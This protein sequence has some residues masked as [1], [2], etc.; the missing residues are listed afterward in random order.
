MKLSRRTALLLTLTL[1]AGCGSSGGVT[2]PTGVRFTL[3]WPDTTRALPLVAKSVR[4]QIKQGTKLLVERLYLA[5]PDSE[6]QLTDLPFATALTLVASAYTTTDGTGTVVASAS[7][8][9]S[10]LKG[11]LEPVTLTLASVI[12]RI[13]TQL[14]KGETGLTLSAIARDSAGSAVLTDP[15][16]WQWQLSDPTLGTLTPTGST[17][18]F[19]ERGF[20]I[21]QLTA[22]EKE[23]GKTGT[24][25]RPVCV[26]EP[27]KTAPTQGRYTLGGPLSSI[28][29]LGD[30][31]F[32]FV[33]G[34][35]LACIDSN[36]TL[37]WQRS[38]PSS[39]AQLTALP[40]G[41]LAVVTSAGLRIHSSET[42][43]FYWESTGSGAP[44]NATATAIFQQKTVAVTNE[45]YLE[46][47]AMTSGDLLWS[48]SLATQTLVWAD[49][50]RL[51]N[52]DRAAGLYAVFQSTLG[53]LTWSTSVPAQSQ[54]VGLR[55][56]GTPPLMLSYSPG[57]L[58]AILL[59]NGAK[60]WSVAASGEQVV[61]TPDQGKVLAFGETYCAS[62][63]AATGTP[64]WSKTGLRQVCGTLPSGDLLVLP[65]VD[66][67][68]CQPIQ[69]L[70]ASDG[71]VLWSNYL[72]YT[73]LPNERF[74]AVRVGS[75]VAVTLSKA[76]TY[77]TAPLY[78]L[79][80]TTG[81]YLWGTTVF[82][83]G[84]PGLAAPVGS[85]GALALQSATG[86]SELLVLH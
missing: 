21:A 18:S 26:G 32:A 3:D 23:S 63:D 47:R 11:K 75:Q 16:Q 2:T 19:V 72:P 82:G 4:V 41:F 10:T 68:T 45:P 38:L 8:P 66:D 76:A 20:G 83:G 24:L 57:E 58:R 30:G 60:L 7:I 73:P 81:Q 39:G 86:S 74:L 53:S 48:K 36:G 78:L 28:L 34:T 35:V 1:T 85:A 77:T 42:G 70:R 69:A 25:T 43:S 64:L 9:F 6:E 52:L 59:A 61:L 84:S 31:R 71:T 12:T 55:T 44:G 22:T 62:Y 14:T 40:G 80:T 65:T 79:D 56:S 49:S 33:H 67:P 50:T 27:S 37:V 54:F 5:G 15:T 13:E 29:G 51:I 46:A 17:A